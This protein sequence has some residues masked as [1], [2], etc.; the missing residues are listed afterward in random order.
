MRHRLGPGRNPER[1]PYQDRSLPP[2]LSDMDHTTDASTALRLEC[3]ATPPFE[4]FAPRVSHAPPPVFRENRCMPPP[5]FKEDLQC[6]T[7]TSNELRD[8]QAAQESGCAW[9]NIDT[10]GGDML[11]NG[12]REDDEG[13]A[14][15]TALQKAEANNRH[16]SSEN[17]PSPQTLSPIG[18]PP[19]GSLG[20]HP[21]ILQ[22]R[23]RE[24]D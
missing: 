13:G 23:A 8:F 1:A 24:V 3:P 11:T 7:Q 22:A 18:T 14:A 19:P 4:P 6:S 16:T 10:I 20:D 9:I 12:W 21:R 17:S 15:W 5:V 2:D